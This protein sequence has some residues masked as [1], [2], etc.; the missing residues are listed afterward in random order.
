MRNRVLPARAHPSARGPAG[1]QTARK[2]SIDVRASS[3]H[4]E[5]ARAPR[6]LDEVAGEARERRPVSARRG[7]HLPA[8]L[9]SREPQ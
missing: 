7:R 2:V 1:T 3:C 4:G 5:V 8:T 6:A 9:L